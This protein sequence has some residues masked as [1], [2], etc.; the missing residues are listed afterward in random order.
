MRIQ[1]LENPSFLSSYFI[2]GRMNNNKNALPVLDKIYVRPQCESQLCFWGSGGRSVRK[3]CPPRVS[4]IAVRFV[5]RDRLGNLF[6][7][8][9]YFVCCRQKKT[10]I[11]YWTKFTPETKLI[12][13][14]RWDGIYAHLKRES[15]SF[16]WSPGD[17]ECVNFCPPR[18]WDCSPFYE[19]GQERKSFFLVVVFR[20]LQN[21][22]KQKRL[23][24]M[25]RKPGNVF[26]IHII[27]CFSKCH[28]K[29]GFRK[30]KF[31]G[32][33]NEWISYKERKVF[34]FFVALFHW[35]HVTAGNVL[36]IRIILCFSK[37]HQELNFRKLKFFG[38][39]KEW[40]SYKEK[41]FFVFF[42]VVFRSLQN[43]EQKNAWPGMPRQLGN[44]FALCSQQIW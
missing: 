15:Q 39:L 44:S 33:L 5:R 6:F 23:A 25:P 31:F 34:S 37:C 2:G 13:F 29:L 26:R 42:V 20:W 9:S 14:S 35:L 27:L 30:L 43:I 36:R 28:Q 10:H 12:L 17:G 3:F 11:Q 24:G 22:N 1:G 38:V 32:V 41:K 4:E 16:S 19:E 8:S 18:I 21:K 7:W 40:T